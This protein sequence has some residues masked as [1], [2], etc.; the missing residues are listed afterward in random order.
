[1]AEWSMGVVEARFADIIWNNEPLSSGQLVKLAEEAL[2]WKRSTTYT[3]LKRLCDRE[4]FQNQNGLVTARITREE[5]QSR[6]SQEFV[7]AS[8][9]GSLPAFITS[10]ASRRKL[11][12]EEIQ[13]LQDLI[14]QSRR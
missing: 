1:M 3:V 5:F 9:G 11:T 12:Q 4:I 2:G 14:D 8:F 6:Q 10:F 7:D 13:Q